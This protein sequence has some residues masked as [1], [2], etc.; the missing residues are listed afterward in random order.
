MAAHR[1]DDKCGHESDPR[2]RLRRTFSSLVSNDTMTSGREKENQNET[3]T[4]QAA[5]LHKLRHIR[6][7]DSREI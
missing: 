1:N 4:Q 2:V 7:D 3:A 6:I 5:I